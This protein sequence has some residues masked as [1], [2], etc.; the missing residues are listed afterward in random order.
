[1]KKKL[2]I[3]IQTFSTIRQEDFLYVDKT[4]IAC[5]LIENGRYYFLSRP[6][7][8]G[9]SLFLS[10][11]SEIFKGSQT[12][13]DGLY[14]ADKWDWDTIY[15]V[16]R[17]SF[18]A[19]NFASK[20]G[21]ND[22][23]YFML[24]ENCRRNN[25][26]I[27]EKGYSLAQ[28][29][30]DLH[31]HYKQQVV[32]LIDEYD[33]PIL[34][35]I[36]N[37]EQATNARNIL[38]DF[39]GSIKECDDFI[40]FVFI[41]GVSKFSKMN[42]FSGLNNLE[43]ITT[44]KDYATICGYTHE[45]LKTVFV[46]HLQDADMKQVKRWYNGYNYFGTPVYNPFDIL[47][48]ISNSCEFSNY[49]WETGN[50]T[51]LIDKLKEQGFYVPDLENLIVARETLSSFDVEHIDL[52]AL[53]WQTGYLTFD[54]KL[55][56]PGRTRY[57]MKVPNLEIK[58]SLNELFLGYFTNLNGV[59]DVQEVHAIEAMI[60]GD[61]I[62]LKETLYALFAAI[63]YNN[64]ANN[65]IANYE[66]Y[67]AAVIYSFFAALGLELIAEDITNKGRIDLTIKIDDFAF[68]IEF[69]VDKNEPAIR[70]INER[71]YYEK[72]QNKF[73]RIFLI[74]INFSSE[75]KNIIDF[76]WEAVEKE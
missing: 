46:E 35:N 66:G 58:T 21:I 13:F 63:P 12:L 2:P 38:R 31:E 70:Q 28:L 45:D 6:R 59:K 26:P 25:L 30:I 5:D 14:I 34:D 60:A 40:R 37:V 41:T 73:K 7:R 11:L 19:G 57:K 18:G 54:H 39:Y 50:P 10:T 55:A 15:P 33:K 51:F 65:I 32:I 67:Y 3:G 23:I 4:A 29:V 47:L 44:H 62:K 49:W 76:Q 74:G 64:Y 56:I 24:K 16:I 53:L 42:L 22:K 69:K 68:I 17:I 61:L 20:A 48:F 1:M 52:I 43:D 9:K 36:T 71:K 72:Y 27:P 75:E 8:F